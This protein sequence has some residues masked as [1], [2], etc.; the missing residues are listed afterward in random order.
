MAEASLRGCHILVVEDEYMLA[1]ELQTELEDIGATVIGPA[2]NIDSALDLIRSAPHL[3]GAIL[4]L[5]LGGAP[6]FSLADA[7]MTRGVPLVFATGYDFSSVPER[8]SHVTRCEKPI[9]IRRITAALGST[10]QT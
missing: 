1:D 7:L 5:N 10:I 8:F 3:D 2:G 4:D 6:A 9:N